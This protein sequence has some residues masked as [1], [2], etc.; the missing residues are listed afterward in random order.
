[1]GSVLLGDNLL[2]SARAPAPVAAITCADFI[3]IGKARPRPG[4]RVGL[5]NCLFLRRESPGL[6]AVG[7]GLGSGRAWGIRFWGMYREALYN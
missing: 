6:L 2:G 4:E 5:K 7:G 1:M 3:P